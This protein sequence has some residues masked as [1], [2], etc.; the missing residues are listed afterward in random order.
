MSNEANLKGTGEYERETTYDK[1]DKQQKMAE[2][3]TEEQNEKFKKVFDQFD[4][5]KDGMISLREIKTVALQI[6]IKTSEENIEKMYH[7]IDINNDGEIN[8]T[9]FLPLMNKFIK[10]DTNGEEH[11]EAYSRKKAAVV[12]RQEN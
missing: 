8:F 3:L 9:E 1:M 6:G 12:A 5:N 7:K 2:S 4:I 10:I 11:T